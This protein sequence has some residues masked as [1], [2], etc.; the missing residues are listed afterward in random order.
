MDNR[1][2]VIRDG[3]EVIRVVADHYTQDSVVPPRITFRDGDG[4]VVKTIVPKVGDVVRPVMVGF[5]DPYPPIDQSLA[6][7]NE[8]TARMRRLEATESAWGQSSREQ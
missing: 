7:I 3:E 2:T 8:L 1:F 4:V 6:R 5:C